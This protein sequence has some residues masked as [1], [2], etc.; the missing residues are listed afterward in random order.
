M[1]GATDV[2]VSY[3]AQDRAR[4]VQLVEALEAEGFAVW[5][6]EQIGGGTAWRQAIE[7]EL[8][9]TNCV[10]V[11]WSKRSVGQGGHFVRD[12]ARR[13]QQRGSYLPIRLDDAEPPLGFGEIQAISLKGWHGD[14]SDGDRMGRVQERKLHADL[15]PGYRGGRIPRLP[16]LEATRANWRAGGRDRVSA[17]ARVRVSLVHNLEKP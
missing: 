7:A 9:S 1:I 2:F 13:A 15:R 5:W 11:A 6:D 16:A 17:W 12:E 8:N 3:K 4:L 10:I 14:R